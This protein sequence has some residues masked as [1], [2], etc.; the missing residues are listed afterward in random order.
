MDELKFQKLVLEALKTINSKT[1]KI[2]RQVAEM[3]P[4]YS[5]N[6]IEYLKPRDLNAILDS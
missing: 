5:C 1:E 2:N 6:M 3:Q 4:F